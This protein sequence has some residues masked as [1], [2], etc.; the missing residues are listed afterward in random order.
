MAINTNNNIF[1]NYNTYE[2]TK[3]AKADKTKAEETAKKTEETKETNGTR[4][5]GNYGRTIGNAKL[6]EAGAKY[7]EKLK[8]KFNNLDFILVSED[9]KANAQANAS[10]YANAAKMVVLIDEDKI[11]RMATDEK[12]RNQYEGVIAQ[13]YSGLNQLKSSIEASGQSGQVKGYGMQIQDNGTAKYFAVLEK[14]AKA[15]TER[16]EKQ[17][18]KKRADRKAEKAKADKAAKEEMLKGT[19]VEAGDDEVVITADSIEELMQ[20]ISEYTYNDRS[21][22]VQTPEEMQVGQSI[23]FKG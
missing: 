9:Q 6:S 2:T 17:V 18:E 19:G 4:K 5:A 11:E 3:N 10:K 7:Y 16:I 8:K 15:Q 12:F 22:A 20:K 1:G 23:D 21:N 13:A 14:S